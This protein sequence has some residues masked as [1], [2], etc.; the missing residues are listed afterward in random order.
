LESDT[1]MSG[2][3][4]ELIA[5]KDFPEEG[6]FGQIWLALTISCPA[7]LL[8]TEHNVKRL[9]KKFVLDMRLDMCLCPHLVHY[10]YTHKLRPPV[11]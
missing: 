2:S 1:N 8:P 7:A 11:A 3:W 5:E 10:L 4:H 9:A 6:K